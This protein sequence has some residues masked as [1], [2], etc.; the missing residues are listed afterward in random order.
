MADDTHDDSDGAKGADR[1]MPADKPKHL[2]KLGGSGGGTHNDGVDYGP[3]PK[4]R[5]LKPS[6]G[7]EG[8]GSFSPNADK[9]IEFGNHEPRRSHS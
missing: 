8:T 6:D 5:E 2:G 4:P 7:D 1:N 9:T 3:T